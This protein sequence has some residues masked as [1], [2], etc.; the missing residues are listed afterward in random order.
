MLKSRPHRDASKEHIEFWLWK[1][2]GWKWRVIKDDSWDERFGRRVLVLT[3]DIVESRPLNEGKDK[4][5][6]WGTCTLRRYLN[7]P[8]FD[9]LPVE[10]KQRVVL[11]ENLSSLHDTDSEYPEDTEYSKD[12]VFL[13]SEDEVGEYLKDRDRNGTF[14]KYGEDDSSEQY[15]ERSLSPLK[16]WKEDYRQY[17]SSLHDEWQEEYDTVLKD[18]ASYYKYAGDSDYLREESAE[19]WWR[20]CAW[21]LRPDDRC[22][23]AKATTYG[24]QNS[25]D[26]STTSYSP[27]AILGVR[28]AL[29]V[30]ISSRN[31]DLDTA[32][33]K[34]GRVPL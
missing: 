5:V 21:W 9:D 33:N 3:E 6:T 14:V 23:V 4:E 17:S 19:A 16:A 11:I 24:I 32:S 18:E 30:D 20:K 12:R 10:V 26:S 7:G 27:D 1:C 34:P 28:A 31:P 22:S 25:Q 8:F 29:C 13:L 15:E 2:T